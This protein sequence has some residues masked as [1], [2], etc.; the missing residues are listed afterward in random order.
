[1]TFRAMP[2]IVTPRR[3]RTPSAHTFASQ[4]GGTRHPDE[5]WLWGARLA[6]QPHRYSRLASLFEEFCACFNDADTVIVAVTAISG[7]TAA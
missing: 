6:F 3:T 5:P 4:V 7:W 1:M 2:C